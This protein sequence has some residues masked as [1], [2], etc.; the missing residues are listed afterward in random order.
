MSRKAKIRE[1]RIYYEDGSQ[2][3]LDS[4]EIEK[5][6]KL[7]DAIQLIERARDLFE[8]LKTLF[9]EVRE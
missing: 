2:L 5:F 4:W 7:S 1:V 9:G 8:S 6:E 3:A